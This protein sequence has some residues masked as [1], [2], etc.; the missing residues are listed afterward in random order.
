MR[1]TA[2][3]IPEHAAD[4]MDDG[5]FGRLYRWLQAGADPEGGC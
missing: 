2:D 1:Q 4:H 3:T 5:L